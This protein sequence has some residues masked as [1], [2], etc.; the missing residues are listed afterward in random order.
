MWLK[1]K[2]MNKSN[3]QYLKINGEKNK[4]LKEKYNIDK[5]PTILKIKNKKKT[6][7][8]GLR[9]ISKLKKFIK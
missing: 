4:K 8:K 2:K 5:Y 1:I 7:F 9:T 3:N 6:F